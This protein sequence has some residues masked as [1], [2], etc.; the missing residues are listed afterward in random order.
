MQFHLYDRH[1]TLI[2]IAEVN[3]APGAW[4]TG[5]FA[6]T[7]AFAV[8]AAQ[9]LELEQAANEQRIPDADRIQANLTQHG[10]WISGPQPLNTRS[11]VQ[12]LQIMGTGICFRLLGA[13]SDDQLVL[14][15]ASRDLPKLVEELRLH[16]AAPAKADQ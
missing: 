6:P 15:R 8:Y 11:D 3:T 14:A 13:A 12:D 9:F 10:F 2:G 16:A 4:L 5:T 7:D 1:T